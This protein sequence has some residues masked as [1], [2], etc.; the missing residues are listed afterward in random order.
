[1]RAIFFGTPT[2]AVPSFLA[3]RAV[4]VDIVAVVTQPDRPRGRSHSTLQPSPVKA[5]ALAAGVPVLQPDRPRDPAFLDQ[6][7]SLAPDLGVVVAYGHLLR[8]ELLAIPRLGLVNVHASL[9]PRW[10]G[11][12][13]IAWALLSGDRETGVSIMR[14]EEGLDT[15]ATWRIERVPIHDTDTSGT[16]TDRLAALGASA[17]VAAVPDVIAGTAPLPQPME[18]VTLA[19]K[20]DRGLARIRWNESGQQVSCRVRAMDPAPGAWTTL[21][22]AEV[23]LFD[24][25]PTA[26]DPGQGR[27]VAAEG[28]LIIG[29]GSGGALSFGTIQPAG[30]RRM[31]AADW[32]RGAALPTDATCE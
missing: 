24:P 4:G 3:L 21:E 16:L 11:A 26:A 13:P 10:R 27:V 28:R 6:L 18:G 19:T 15:G 7:R 17:L 31:P 5:A 12:A 32:L 29:C 30:K 9:L 2:F 8:P 22:G 25:T 20:I 14:V 1:M 23:K